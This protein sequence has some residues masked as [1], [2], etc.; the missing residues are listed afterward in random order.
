[1]PGGHHYHRRGYRYPYPYPV[2]YGSDYPVVVS[3]DDCQCK[4]GSGFEQK[5]KENPLVFL[6]GALF[7][8]FLLAKKR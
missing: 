2:N 4:A 8:G 3:Q 1:M 5:I 6:V 7:V